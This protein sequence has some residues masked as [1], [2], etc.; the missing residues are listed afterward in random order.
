M[1]CNL[2]CLEAL[3]RP[4]FWGIS[5]PGGSP[6]R[7]LELRGL[8]IVELELGC[9]MS[10]GLWSSG[11]QCIENYDAWRLLGVPDSADLLQR[12][13]PPSAPWSFEVQSFWN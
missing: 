6:W 4:R 8:Q 10:G 11:A 7:I 5:A 12:V 1:H 13:G 3:G 9:R 2:Q